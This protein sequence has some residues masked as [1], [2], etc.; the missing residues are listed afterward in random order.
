MISTAQ[1]QNGSQDT[2]LIDTAST[3]TPHQAL[4][5][6]TPQET[7]MRPEDSRLLSFW[8]D[9]QRVLTRIAIATIVLAIGLHFF[10][11]K[12]LLN[13]QFALGVFTV[14]IAA[15]ALVARPHF[16]GKSRAFRK[17]MAAS[18]WSNWSEVQ[19]LSRQL[20]QRLSKFEV[21]R[22]QALA[23]AGT[24][25]LNTAI[26]I[27]DSF[28]TD[29][30]VSPTQFWSARAALYCVEERHPAEALSCYEHLLKRQPNNP[31]AMLEA[32]LKF[33]YF[34][35]EIAKA[36][37]ILARLKSMTIPPAQQYNFAW[38][39]GAVALKKGRHAEAVGHLQHALQ[40]GLERL[41]RTPLGEPIVAVIEGYLV[42]ALTGI[43]Q[44]HEAAILAK[45]HEKVLQAAGY[46]RLHQK[47]RLALQTVL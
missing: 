42:L 25:D 3:N 27:I 16:F 24:G 33:V 18:V 41:T 23:K 40:I 32:A 1:N 46:H 20:E 22:Y 29:S 45:Q 14:V 8:R 43:D 37:Q 2:L 35:Y 4:T 17:L 5:F 21:A 47:I 6:E 9:A 44:K 12:R 38:L 39:E 7:I 11:F 36:E 13:Y 31:E 26:A 30:M 28:K 34:D 10:G 19:R 15:L